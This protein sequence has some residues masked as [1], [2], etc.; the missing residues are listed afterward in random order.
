LA[1]LSTP[2][3]SLVFCSPRPNE[4]RPLQIRA[5][6][7]RMLAASGRYRLQVIRFIKP[8][9]T[10]IVGLTNELKGTSLRWPSVVAKVGQ[11]MTPLY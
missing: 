5:I 1:G 4:A 3:V 7:R 11:S 9:D 8:T 2:F 10:I 6:A